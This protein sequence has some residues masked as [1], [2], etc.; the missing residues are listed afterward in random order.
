MKYLFRFRAVMRWR[1]GVAPLSR[2][3]SAL[4][5]EA[6]RSGL[7]TADEQLG[8]PAQRWSRLGGWARGALERDNTALVGLGQ[9]HCRTEIPA[10]A[11]LLSQLAG[12]CACRHRPGQAFELRAAIILQTNP[13]GATVTRRPGRRWTRLFSLLNLIGCGFSGAIWGGFRLHGELRAPQIV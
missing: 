1:V 3:G 7:V 9:A 10:P 4:R 11:L 12:A 2:A 5:G 8:G 13:A 6:A